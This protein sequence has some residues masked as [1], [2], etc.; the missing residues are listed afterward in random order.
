M[1]RVAYLTVDSNGDLTRRSTITLVGPGET[2]TEVT[3]PR[4]G[5][6][7][8]RVDAALTCIGWRVAAGAQH[9]SRFDDQGR[10]AF[11]VEKVDPP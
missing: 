9:T 11:D 2:R 3:V 10:L 1:T 4:R 8:E 5:M 6:F 7:W